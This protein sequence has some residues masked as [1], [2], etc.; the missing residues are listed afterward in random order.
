MSEVMEN[1]SSA[2]RSQLL[3]R[4]EERLPRVLVTDA[5]VRGTLTACRS[6]RDDGYAVDAVEASE[7]SPAITHWSRACSNRFLAPDP[8]RDRAGFARAL[9]QLLARE[10]HSILL[11]GSDAALLAISERPPDARRVSDLEQRPGVVSARPPLR[12]RALQ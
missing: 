4:S 11:P 12:G 9:A 6:L 5:A 8:R 1:Q 7:P 10:G 3:L 2:G